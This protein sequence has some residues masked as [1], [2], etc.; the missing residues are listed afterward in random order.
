MTASEATAR[1]RRL[2]GHDCPLCE[3]PGVPHGFV[4]CRVCWAQVPARLRLALN[5]AYQSRRDNPQAHRAALAA[6]LEW[7]RDQRRGREL[8]DV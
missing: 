7:C 8:A 2:P 1:G 5:H 6:V 3:I 4:T